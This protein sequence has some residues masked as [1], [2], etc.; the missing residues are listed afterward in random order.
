M[1]KAFASDFDRTLYFRDGFHEE[2]VLA[3]RQWQKNGFLFGVCTGR[4]KGGVITPTKGL[5]DYD[6]YILATGSLILDKNKEV[7]Y[8]KKIPLK[9]VYDISET[10]KNKYHIA[11]NCRENFYSLYDEYEICV[12]MKSMDELPDDV[13][14][15]SIPM[16]DTAT[17]YEACKFL[18]DH[19]PV[20][21]FNNGQ[22]VDM[23]SKD[24]SKGNALHILKEKLSLDEV[25]CIGDSYNDITMLEKGDVSF[26][27]ESSPDL[28][29]QKAGHVVSSLAEAISFK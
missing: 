22:F 28:V 4:S 25:R 27:F 1:K 12:Q 16:E 13:F 19:Y 5:I 9:A 3:I 10:Y 20:S 14:G 6:F 15:I 18:N 11:Y 21:A 8:E 29:K 24:C 2:D 23:T 26:T 17:A 7:I